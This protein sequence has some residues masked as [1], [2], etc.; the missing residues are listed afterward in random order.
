MARR[1][2]FLTGRCLMGF[3]EEKKNFHWFFLSKVFEIAESFLRS[4]VNIANDF[5]IL[6]AEISLK[7]I[8][9]KIISIISF[10]SGNNDVRKLFRPCSQSIVYMIVHYLKCLSD[11]ALK[12]SWLWVLKWHR[13]II[14]SNFTPNVLNTSLCSASWRDQNL[15]KTHQWI[16]FYS[17]I[18][19]EQFLKTRINLEIFTPRAKNIDNYP[20]VNVG[21]Q[22]LFICLMLSLHKLVR[23]KDAKCTK[24]TVS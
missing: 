9:I 5:S 7:K 12:T 23:E 21:S 19:I 17:T 20:F 3:G 8:S 10:L 14:P 13:T 24:C 4:E 1:T 15:T 11:R 6:S 18:E 22:S 2:P 16:S